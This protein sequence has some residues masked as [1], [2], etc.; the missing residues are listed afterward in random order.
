[1]DLI[2]KLNLVQTKEEPETDILNVEASKLLNLQPATIYNKVNKRNS[3]FQERQKL[4]FSKSGLIFWL[5][6][7]SDRFRNQKKK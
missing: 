3:T 6:K 7:E 1:M 2:S 5:K 4:Y